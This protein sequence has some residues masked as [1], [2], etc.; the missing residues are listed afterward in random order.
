LTGSPWRYHFR[1]LTPS[2]T[3]F[4]IVASQ[5]DLRSVAYVFTGNKGDRKIGSLV[6][7]RSISGTRHRAR[8]WLSWGMFGT[9]DRFNEESSCA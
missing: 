6:Q 1:Y 3:F 5:H 2:T 9:P 8:G 4:H 7:Y